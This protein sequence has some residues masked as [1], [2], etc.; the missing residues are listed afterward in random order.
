MDSPETQPSAATMPSG[1]VSF[2]RFL[3]DL[4]SIFGASQ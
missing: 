2:M 3:D 4:Q 1:S